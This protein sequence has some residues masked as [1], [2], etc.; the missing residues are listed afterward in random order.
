MAAMATKR[1]QMNSRR[2]RWPRKGGLESEVSDARRIANGD[3]GP[4]VST[5]IVSGR[6]SHRR[7]SA[8]VCRGAVPSNESVGD[9]APGPPGALRC[10]ELTHRARRLA[11]ERTEPVATYLVPTRS[12]TSSTGSA[13]R[14]ERR[15][16]GRWASR[17]VRFM[18]R[19]TQASRV[20]S[21]DS[22]H[23]HLPGVHAD[24]GRGR[25]DEA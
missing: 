22:R 13:R 2:S 1:P 15:S 14:N 17:H 12:T 4:T 5:V 20:D 18:T 6:A 24:R 11:V 9:V 21:R 25:R 16:S 10:R 8:H 3:L 7:G 19:R 23:G